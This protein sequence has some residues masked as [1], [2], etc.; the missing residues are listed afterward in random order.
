MMGVI[1]GSRHYVGSGLGEA[2]WR[3]PSCGAENAGP[4]AQG[5]QL[6]GAGK[7]GRRVVDRDGEAA[8]PPPPPPPATVHTEH[9]VATDWLARHPEATL[10]QAFTAG[11]VEGVRA[12][13]QAEQA[14]RPAPA[15]EETFTP[16]DK[17]TRTIIAALALF[18]DQILAGD[19]EEVASGEWCSGAEVTRLIE[20][21]QGAL[22]A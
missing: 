5:C 8:P 7:P 16:E 15:P 1:T 17:I 13:R 20:Q 14:R 22:H 21:L 18:R 9:T 3:C 2:T 10:E 6:C 12:A 11:Y 4:L 19:P